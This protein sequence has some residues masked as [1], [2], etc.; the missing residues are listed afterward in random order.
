MVAVKYVFGLFSLRE[1]DKKRLEFLF[2]L[3]LSR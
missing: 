1:K 2:G 3:D